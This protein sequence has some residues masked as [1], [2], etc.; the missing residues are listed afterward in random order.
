M[1]KLIA[2]GDSIFAG[3]NGKSQDSNDQLIPELIGQALGWEVTNTAISGAQFDDRDSGFPNMARTHSAAGYDYAIV[4]FGVNNWCFPSGG[5]GYAARKASEG[6]DALK[7]ENPNIKILLELPTEDF[8]NGS[9][10]LFDLNSQGWT[11][12]QLD[13]DWRPNPIITYTNANEKLGDGNTGVHPTPAT[14]KEI[15]DRLVA[16]FKQMIAQSKPSEPD[17]PQPNQP[18]VNT[19]KLAELTDV[20]KIGDNLTNNVAAAISFVNSLYDRIGNIYGMLDSKKIEMPVKFD[21]PLQRALRNEVIKSFIKLNIYLNELIRYC[22]KEGIMNYETGEYA[23]T[24]EL[25]LPRLLTIDENYQKIINNNWKLIEDTLNQVS[26][27][28]Q[29]MEE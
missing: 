27:D 17:N 9:T 2:F 18:V 11:Q 3:W 14:S 22:K 21:K 23:P 8:R 20:F 1:T 10:T 19:L 25:T 16:K 28:L 13:D 26:N 12:N 24:I 15:A 6:I 29:E 5:V 7:A 4:N